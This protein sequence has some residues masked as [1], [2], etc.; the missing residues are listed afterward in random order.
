MFTTLRLEARQ[1]ANTLITC[2]R[3]IHFVTSSNGVH[4]IGGGVH[5][6]WR[7]ALLNLRSLGQ[8]SAF[9]VKLG[10]KCNESQNLFL[11]LVA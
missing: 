2:P 8:V 10:L 9:T 6:F 7:S 3:K 5:S 1:I 4:M 11:M